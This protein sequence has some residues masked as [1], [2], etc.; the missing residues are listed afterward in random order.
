MRAWCGE[1][2]HAQFG[3]GPMEKG[4]QP[5]TSPAA[6]PTLRGLGGRKAPWLPDRFRAGEFDRGELRLRL[7]A[8]QARL[9][10][11]LRRGQASPDRK[12]A[13]LCR[14]LRKWWPALGTF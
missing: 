13:G 6:Y 4:R 3:G 1:S 10:R 9:G 14:E 2:S 11:L 5:G 12:T 7:I 8:L